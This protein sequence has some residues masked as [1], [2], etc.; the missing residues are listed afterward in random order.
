MGRFGGR[1]LNETLRQK[2]VKDAKVHHPAQQD[3]C[4]KQPTCGKSGQKLRCFTNSLQTHQ[5]EA[6]HHRNGKGYA[7]PNG[8]L[9]CET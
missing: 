9:G 5:A 8:L 3:A 4:R 6:H 7:E 1:A 2:C